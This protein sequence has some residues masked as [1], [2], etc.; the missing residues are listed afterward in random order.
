MLRRNTIRIL[1]RFLIYV[2]FSLL[3][4]S[5]LNILH[6]PESSLEATKSF[7]TSLKNPLLQN[8]WR[9]D[10]AGSEY[11]SKAVQENLFLNTAQCMKAFPG[12]D[13]EIQE[14]MDRGPFPLKRIKDNSL[15]PAVQGRIK[16]G[17]VCFGL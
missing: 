1:F 9:G 7:I 10:S 3:L 8:V 14:A 16:D 11:P 2:L 15:G 4:F 13:T 6:N 12:F 17:K 5:S